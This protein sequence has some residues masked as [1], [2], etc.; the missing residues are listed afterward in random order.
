MPDALTIENLIGLESLY[1]AGAYGNVRIA[2]DHLPR[3]LMRQLSI[4]RWAVQ[5]IDAVRKLTNLRELAFELYPTDGIEPISA[6]ND[7]TYLRVS[8]GKGWASLRECVKLEEAHLIDVR[9][10]NL[11]RWGTWKR[12]RRLVLTGTGL[13]SLAGMEQFENLENLI[14]TMVGC[15]DLEPLSGLAHL[16][17]LTLRYVAASR[18][19]NALSDLA[20]LARLTI[21]QSVGS[22]RD[23]IR[24]ESLRPLAGLVNLQ[25]V[26]LLG[27]EICDG[28]LTPLIGLPKLRKVVLGRHLRADVDKLRAARPDIEID[29][30]LPPAK[31]AA[32]VDRV[33]QITIHGPIGELK[34]WSIYDRARFSSMCA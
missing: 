34:Q 19:L 12:L 9:I 24:I 1:A 16:T 20:G 26:L 13:K 27:T 3:N 28:D 11:R 25:E 33:G 4:P 15:K 31:Q 23:I 7:L 29:H 6:L 10:A 17:D 14:L 18:N 32:T 22:N 5:D 2:L 21:N 30:H 8:S